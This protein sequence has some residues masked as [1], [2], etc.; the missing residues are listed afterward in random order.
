MK[1]TTIG[2]LECLVKKGG[3]QH[4]VLF[5]G[6]GANSADLYPLCHEILSPEEADRFTWIF[7]NG[8]LPMPHFHGRAWFPID[9]EHLMSKKGQDAFMQSRPKGLEEARLLAEDFFQAL[10]VPYSQLI[11]GG[12]SQGAMLATDCTLNLPENPLGLLILSGFLIDHKGWPS[13]MMGRAGTR[14]CQTHGYQD[15]ILHYAGA[16]ELTTLLLEAG[17]HGAMTAFRGGHT[18]APQALEALALFLRASL[19]I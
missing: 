19:A 13:R 9:M 1:K 6:Y 11:L 7:P 15:D 16:K 8:P 3:E 4:I 12:F 17:W 14:F 2:P 10:G 5:H 18:I